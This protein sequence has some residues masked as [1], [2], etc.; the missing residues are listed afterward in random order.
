MVLCCALTLFAKQN[1]NP[2]RDK[3]FAWSTYI[4]CNLVLQTWMK[5]QQSYNRVSLE[6]IESRKDAANTRWCIRRNNR[7]T[8]IS[9]ILQYPRL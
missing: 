5:K 7:R 8:E 6:P 2:A 3:L 4:R 1:H 9:L